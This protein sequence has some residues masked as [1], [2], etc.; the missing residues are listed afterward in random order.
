MIQSAINSMISSAGS[1]A[2]AIK[3]QQPN[4][5]FNAIDMK[6]AMMAN[7]RAKTSID[8]KKKLKQSRRKVGGR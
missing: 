5:S 4:P 3:P 7:D 1:V 2:G 8:V 6:K